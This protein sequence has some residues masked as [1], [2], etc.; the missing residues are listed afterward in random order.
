MTRQKSS[1]LTD[2]ELEVMHVVWDLE[3]GTVRQ[4]HER[5]NQQRPLAYTTV[6]GANSISGD[7]RRSSPRPG[8]S[9]K[10]S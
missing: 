5:L 1:R 4:V 10:K 2:L 9:Q 7:P 6:I 3:R 8:G